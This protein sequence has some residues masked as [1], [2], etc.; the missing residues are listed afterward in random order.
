MGTFGVNCASYWWTRVAACG[1]R[2]THHLLNSLAIT[3]RGRIAIVLSYCLTALQYPFKW[4]GVETEYSSYGLGLTEKRA[5]WLVAW[6]R[7]KIQARN[8]DGARLAISLHGAFPGAAIC[9]V[10]RYPRPP[11]SHDDTHHV[12]GPFQF[13]WQIGDRLQRPSMG[14]RLHGDSPGLR[15][16]VVLPGSR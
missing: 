8:V 2:A 11:G 12:E 7:E 5:G 1:V 4:L 13:G 10:L 16:A 14:G 9:L 15:G 3:R 6:L